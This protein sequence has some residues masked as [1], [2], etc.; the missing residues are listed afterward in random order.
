MSPRASDAP[1]PHVVALGALAVLAAAGV[2]A[3]YVLWV[4]TPAGQ[5]LDQDAFDGCGDLPRRPQA[6]GDLL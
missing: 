4:R 6:A 2:V 5:Q 1:R 3:T